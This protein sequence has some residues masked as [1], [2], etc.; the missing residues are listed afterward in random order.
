MH[1]GGLSGLSDRTILAFEIR[2]ALTF[3]SFDKLEI[4]AGKLGGKGALVGIKREQ[5][6]SPFSI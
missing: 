1:N 4:A 5:N 2:I 6:S 3:V